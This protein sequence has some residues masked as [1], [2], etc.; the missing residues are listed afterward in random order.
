MIKKYIQFNE[1]VL[2]HLTG[3]NEEEVWKEFGYD[4]PFNSPQEFL[5]YITSDLEEYKN[6]TFPNSLFLRKDG[7][8]LFEIVYDSNLIYVEY[9]DV[10]EIL[11]K[12]FSM[13]VTQIKEL[14]TNYFTQNYYLQNYHVFHYSNLVSA[15]WWFNTKNNRSPLNNRNFKKVNEGVLDKLKGP[16]TGDVWKILGYD[17]TF[18]TTEDYFTFVFNNLTVS[19]KK[20]FY[21]EWKDVE[22]KDDDGMIVISY[23]KLSKYVDCNL[24]EYIDIMYKMFD[25]SYDDYIRTIRN[26]LKK[27]LMLDNDIRIHFDNW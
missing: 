11:E 13:S 21:D 8:I 20:M 26:F 12:I 1:G 10:Y 16:D 2:Q 15:R 27:E 19:R 22:W 17:R 18:D 23:N 25:L 3:P 7:K 4:K 5:D 9:F 14:I 24:T 6:P